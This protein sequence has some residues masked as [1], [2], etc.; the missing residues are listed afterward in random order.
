MICSA[1]QQLCNDCC[2]CVKFLTA[3][4]IAGN[5]SSLG[6]HM[7]FCLLLLLAAVGPPSKVDLAPAGSD[8]DV[9]ISDPLT[10]KNTTMRDHFKLYYGILYWEHTEDTQ[11][12]NARY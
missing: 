1:A 7:S 2:S 4:D 11:V 9:Y 5:L 8:L 12:G 10:S 3:V 6:S